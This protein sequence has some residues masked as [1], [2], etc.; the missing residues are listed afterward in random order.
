MRDKKKGTS[1]TVVFMLENR[2]KIA[3]DLA[4]QDLGVQGAASITA[5]FSATKTGSVSSLYGA[6]LKL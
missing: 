4:S 2:H 3:T 5:R 6:A 1:G